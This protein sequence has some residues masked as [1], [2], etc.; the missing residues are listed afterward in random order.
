MVTAWPKGFPGLGTSAERFAER[1]GAATD[2]ALSIKVMAAGELVG[3]FETFDAVSLGTADMYHAGEYYFQGKH[4]AFN[5]FT[6]VPFGLTANEI[7]S[8]VKFGGGQELWDELSGRFGI[9]PLLVANTGAQMGGWFKREI[10]SVEDLRG[11]K[12][13]MPGLGGEVMR[14]LGA[15]VVALAGGD[16]FAALQSGAIDAAEWIGPWNDMA[17]GFHQA[18]PH[19]YFPGFH[20]P[21]SALAL[22][23][24]KGVWESLSP[25]ERAIFEAVAEAEHDRSL[26]EFNARNA[27]ALK[28]LA[29][30]H[31]VVAKSFSDEILREI[32][33]VSGELLA[34]IA[35]EDEFSRRVYD[36]FRAFRA[37][38]M[39][40]GRVAE[41]SFIAARR[42]DFP[43]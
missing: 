18:A 42:L 34:E 11:L 8:W 31:G 17:F 28:T 43:Y 29:S 36:S 20:E 1:V 35:A 37:D 10:D 41:A 22:G 9:K 13:R 32:G 14:R 6:G 12:I 30:E 39:A 19:Y 21:G 27:G 5:F 4:K 3:A 26:A 23:V 15:A 16:I 24:N 25:A 7:S 33:R 38:A 40:W 2:G